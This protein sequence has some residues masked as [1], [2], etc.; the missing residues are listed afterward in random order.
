MSDNVSFCDGP[1]CCDVPEF[2]VTITGFSNGVC[3]GCDQFNGEF[4][5]QRSGEC[6]W[7]YGFPGDI[8]FCGNFGT[9]SISLYSDGAGN[10]KVDMWTGLLD[11]WFR[12]EGVSDDCGEEIQLT[13]PFND[14]DCEFSNITAKANA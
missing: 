9:P 4:T 7:G 5:L 6:A 11:I 1:A 8:D 2:K 14:G 10:W 13:P 3:E 12:W